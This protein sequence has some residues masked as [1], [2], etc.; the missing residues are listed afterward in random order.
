M[1]FAMASEQRIEKILT[2]D[3]QRTSAAPA[4]DV[5][6]FLGVVEVELLLNR[7]IET[8]PDFADE[9]AQRDGEANIL[10][11]KDLLQLPRQ[12]LSRPIRQKLKK[13]D[14]DENIDWV[15]ERIL[16]IRMQEQMESSLAEIGIPLRIANALEE[17]R[18]V[19]KVS[20]LLDLNQSQD[21]KC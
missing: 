18:E 20:Q 9:L 4:T 3:M 17:Q 14:P 6:P 7:L 15:E 10:L 19:T 12:T 21:E 1:D 2:L 8:V 5:L 16:T 13:F 11:I